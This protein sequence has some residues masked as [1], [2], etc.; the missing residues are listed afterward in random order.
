M[1]AT[2]ILS[3]YVVS[4][5]NGTREVEQVACSTPA[6]ARRTIDAGNAVATKQWSWRLSPINYLDDD[7]CHLST[8]EIAAIDAEAT[9]AP[10]GSPAEGDLVWLQPGHV[11]PTVALHDAY[12][13]ADEAGN[14][15]TWPIDAR[16]K[17][18]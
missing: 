5:F 7:G 3:Q 11:D 12:L 2:Q 8:D 6:E 10:A 18:L 16:R 1:T 14:L 4:H 9:A 13:V 17:T 15:E